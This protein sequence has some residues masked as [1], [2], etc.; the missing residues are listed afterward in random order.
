MFLKI[1][2]LF[3]KWGKFDDV[4]IYVRKN[5]SGFVTFWEIFTKY[6]KLL[7]R[8]KILGNRQFL[9]HLGI[10]HRAFSWIL[11]KNKKLNK[12]VKKRKHSCFLRLN[13]T[14]FQKITQR[15]A[16]TFPKLYNG[17]APFPEDFERRMPRAQIYKN[18]WC[19]CRYGVYLEFSIIT[20]SVF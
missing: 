7:K 15:V 5:A 2:G 11:T 10:F 6:L 14:L 18:S 12:S 20:Y 9:R 3:G 4:K 13:F 19:C 8:V 1:Y 16:Y 17:S